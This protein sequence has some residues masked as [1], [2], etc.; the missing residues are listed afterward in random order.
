[1]RGEINW[2]LIRKRINKQNTCTHTQQRRD[3]R[4]NGKFFVKNIYVLDFFFNC[5]EMRKGNAME[6]RE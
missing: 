3:G 6:K 1:M 5:Y 4:M 2:D